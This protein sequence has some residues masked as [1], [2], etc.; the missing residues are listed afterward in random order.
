MRSAIL[1]SAVTGSIVFAG[2]WA[3]AQHAGH[4]SRHGSHAPVT[5][6]RELVEFPPELVSHTLANMRDHLVALQEI[7]DAL[8]RGA[9]DKA[10]AISE[11]RLGMTSLRLHGA[12]EVAKYMPQ[13]MQDAGSEMHRA[14]SR[15]A[16]EAK[17]SGVTGDL[18]PALAAL[19]SVISQCA[20]CHAGYRLR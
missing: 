15:F 1:A 11:E 20:G 13:G 9:T 3:L 14:A 18:K 4:G 16:I 5:D 2:S 8:S 6:S 7:N 19:S 17:N 12:H 10:A